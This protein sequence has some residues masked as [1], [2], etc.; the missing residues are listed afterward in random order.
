MGVA[1]RFAVDLIDVPFYRHEPV[2][3]AAVDR[4]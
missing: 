2:I 4:Q 3:V 1:G